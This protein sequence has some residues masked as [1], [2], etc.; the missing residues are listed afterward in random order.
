[1][2]DEILVYLRLN[3]GGPNIL[4]MSKHFFFHKLFYFFINSFF[5]QQIFPLTSLFTKLI[6]SFM[7]CML[8]TQ[9]NQKGNESLCNM[10]KVSCRPGS[11]RVTSIKVTFSM[12]NNDSFLSN[13]NVIRK[14][15]KRKF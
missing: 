4:L 12:I 7:F 14:N 11:L 1:M 10:E 5:V 3:L 2:F 13:L 6:T 9:E 8:F 15:I